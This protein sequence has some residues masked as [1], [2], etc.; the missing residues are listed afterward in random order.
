M[1]PGRRVRADQA[2]RRINAAGEL[3]AG[4]ADLPTAAQELARRYRLS[5]RQAR[6]YL[7]RA[8]VGG[9][10]EVP[11]SKVVF[12]VKI[13]REVVRRVKQHARRRGQSIGALVTQ[14]LVEF[15]DRSQASG[16]G[17]Q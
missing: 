4:A 8:R 16:G 12:P 2:A 1:S 7:E 15:L 14:A 11:S 17:G 9:R 10:V 13:A 3:L 5:E 6:R